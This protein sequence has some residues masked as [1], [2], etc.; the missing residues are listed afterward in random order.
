MYIGSFCLLAILPDEQARVLTVVIFEQL[1][2]CL[3]LK[4]LL[5]LITSDDINSPALEATTSDSPVMSPRPRPLS[6]Q[7]PRPR[8]PELLVTLIGRSLVLA[9]VY[10]AAKVGKFV[11]RLL[12]ALGA[13]GLG[14]AGRKAGLFVT[15]TP[16]VALA[17]AVAW[18]DAEVLPDVL[19]L[20]PLVGLG[21]ALGSG[22]L[23]GLNERR[24]ACTTTWRP[25]LTGPPH[26]LG[27][28]LGENR[29]RCGRIVLSGDI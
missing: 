24:E 14:L 17:A 9:A 15:V 27:D 19:V 6:I 21:Y 28:L 13:L 5:L 26:L 8:P 11:T 4:H 22:T 7:R 20:V 1:V 29:F 23:K 2:A 18:L 10:S 16:P 3:L 12:V 25:P